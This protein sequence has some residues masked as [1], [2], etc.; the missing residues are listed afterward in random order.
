MKHVC[1]LYSGG[2]DSFLL[3]KWGKAQGCEITCVFFDIG[4]PNVVK[5][6]AAIKVLGIAA[7]YRRI[8]WLQGL[9]LFSNPSSLSG[10][11]M[12]PG[13]NLVLCA[14]AASI[15]LPNEIWLG[16]LAGETH[17]R[18]HDKNYRF[19]EQTNDL[20]DYV[21]STYGHQPR[22]VFPFADL[23][24]S[25]LDVVRELMQAGIVTADEVMTTSSCLLAGEQ[26]NCG[27]CVVC[28]RRWGIF[29]QLGF[30]E[31]YAV[32]PLASKENRRIVY[33]M[34]RPSS[35]YDDKRKA[36]VLPAVLKVLGLP[37]DCPPLIVERSLR[38]A[39]SNEGER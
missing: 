21:F 27:E 24:W 29:T 31:S 11:I 17:D 38:W 30:E 23:G 20:F 16:A 1:L 4:Q 25:K 35:H 32:S 13:R 19:L 12:I 33:E 3:Y 28:L 5:E 10:N 8:E 9:P 7:E 6:L 14:L 15:Y 37:Q 2:L 39:F 18:A 26:K 36:E 22:L 34:L